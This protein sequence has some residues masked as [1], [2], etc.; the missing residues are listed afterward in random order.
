M[1]VID[2]SRQEI[3]VAVWKAIQSIKSDG[4]DAY[5]NGKEKIVY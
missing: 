3:S 5:S 2:L 1:I 4:G